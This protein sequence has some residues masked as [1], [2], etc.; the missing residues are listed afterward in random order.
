MA[1]YSLEPEVAGEW[2]D[3][4]VADVSVHPPRVQR[5]HYQFDGWL[6]DALLESFPCYIVSNELGASLLASGLTGFQLEDC[7][8]SKSSQFDELY[9][10]RQLPVFKWL[11]VSGTPGQDDFGISSDNELVVSMAAKSVLEEHQVE[12]CEVAPWSS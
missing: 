4:T 1:F 12:H 11:R 8:V 7:T 3:E 9:P 6:G 5:L 10:G 2:G